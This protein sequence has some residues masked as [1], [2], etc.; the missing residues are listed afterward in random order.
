MQADLQ[1]TFRPL[2]SDDVPAISLVHQR[3]C[4]I[5]Y[6]FMNW[7]YPLSEI[8]PWYSSKFSDWTWTRGAFHPDGMAGFI[9]V[10]GNHIDQLFID[11]AHQRS[12]IGTALLVEALR[13]T[14]GR[15]TLHVF[16]ANQTART[17]Y[18][19]HGFRESDKWMN[20]DDHA[21]ELL[22]VRED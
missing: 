16:E 20:L 6:R 11:P 12:G 3:A 22:Y 15:T 4:L 13:S 7:S 5:A 17:L 10:S 9:A 18:E 19:K 2:R 1:L 21:I 8:E 14:S